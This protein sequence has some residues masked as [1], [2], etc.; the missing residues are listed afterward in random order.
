[1]SEPEQGQD[2]LHAVG[3]SWHEGQEPS[4]GKESVCMEEAQYG[5]SESVNEKGIS[6]PGRGGGGRRVEMGDRLHAE[7]IIKFLIY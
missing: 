6:L 7:R 1:M 5:G 2:S 4:Q 3:T